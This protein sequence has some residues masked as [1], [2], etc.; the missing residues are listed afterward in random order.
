MK[1][2]TL[3]LVVAS[4]SGCMMY[5][6]WH[7]PHYG[8]GNRSEGGNRAYANQAPRGHDQHRDDDRGRSQGDAQQ[9][10]DSRRR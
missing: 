8:G 9:S 2:L 10:N 3:L 7:G 1:T 5:P 6:G 4:L